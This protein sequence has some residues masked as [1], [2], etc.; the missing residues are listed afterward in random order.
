MKIFRIVTGWTLKFTE[1]SGMELDT[2]D[3]YIHP[4]E[5]T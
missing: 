1:I 2:V 3:M 4:T 5:T